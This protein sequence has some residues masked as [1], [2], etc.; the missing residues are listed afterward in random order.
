[1]TPADELHGIGEGEIPLPLTLTL[2]DDSDLGVPFGLPP[3]KNA[4]ATKARSY[5]ILAMIDAAKSGANGIFY[6]RDTNF[7]TPH[8]Q[9]PKPVWL[10]YA[11]V[12]SAVK[13]LEAAAKFFR[14][15][16]A[17]R[18]VPKTR[19]GRGERS[20][21][22]FTD[23][24]IDI[25]LTL[26]PQTP[27]HQ[28]TG[29]VILRDQ[30]KR[31]ITYAPTAWTQSIER[32]FASY[33]ETLASAQFSLEHPAAVRID[34]HCYAIPSGGR[35]QIIDLRR[36]LPVRIFNVSLDRGGRFYRTF[37]DN[38]PKEYRLALMIDGQPVT[39]HDFR[40]CHPRIAYWLVGR[41][42]LFDALGDRD[43]Y[44]IEGLSDRWRSRI[45]RA[46]NIMFNA[47]NF[48]QAK[49]AIARELP[50]RP[51][52]RRDR[53]AANLMRRIKHAHP[54]LASLWHSGVGLTLQY[55]D[56]CILQECLAEL[57]ER[58]IVGL[59]N[60]DSIIV[61]ARHRDALIEIMERNFVVIG[62]RLA[63]EADWQRQNPAPE[64][65]KSRAIDLMKWKAELPAGEA[66]ATRGLQHR[67]GSE[68][69]LGGA[70]SPN[71]RRAP[72]QG[73]LTADPDDMLRDVA[74]LARTSG[75]L[76]R[77]HI[78][79]AY[80]ALA[81]RTGTAEQRHD[82]LVSWIDDT[83]RACRS[84]PPSPD[85]ILTALKDI[86]SPALVTGHWAAKRLKVTSALSKKL[87][88]SVIQPEPL[89]KADQAA[90]ARIRRLIN[91]GLSRAVNLG[92]IKPWIGTGVSRAA[93]YDHIPNEIE[94]RVDAVRAL[95]KRRDL[96]TLMQVAGEIEI[97]QRD[98]QCIAGHDRLPVD[99]MLERLAPLIAGALHS[100]TAAIV[101]DACSTDEPLP[102]QAT[103]TASDVTGCV[104]LPIV[105]A[106]ASS[107][108]TASTPTTLAAGDVGGCDAS[109]GGAG[110]ENCCD[111]RSQIEP[112]SADSPSDHS[113]VW[114]RFRK[115]M[116]PDD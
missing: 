64:Q 91:G 17:R 42:D 106:E 71:H 63:R 5:L 26:Y 96:A 24:F 59:S 41:P 54:A 49:G 98:R 74:T 38:M 2:P 84:T 32:F 62:Q 45:K 6:S 7:Y 107:V 40:S 89:T 53:L 14:H 103:L 114:R 97:T 72:S 113:G 20:S 4:L 65:P 101:C 37:W 110:S 92:K 34:A 115:I 93:Y 52:L 85:E 87:A 13:D 88:L 94:R 78:S 70:P 66:I 58:D 56:S 73:G 15:R 82:D 31:E 3:A 33:A 16:L 61:Q 108:D 27:S 75:R 80:A 44:T 81:A 79:V 90:Q 57:T 55:I 25:A 50:Y 51:S 105:R 43:F 116:R 36:R 22:Q 109:S 10:T 47:A 100:E 77:P 111:G 23:L 112:G 48:A 104:K 46:V 69:E 99:E 19:V 86:E 67:S 29:R 60:H 83:C 9:S 11:N 18:Q 35:R 68:E 39:E 1:M 95:I 76:G 28:T 8:E 102:E 21:I 12:L 30:K